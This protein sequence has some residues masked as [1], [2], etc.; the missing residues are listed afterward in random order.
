VTNSAF[1]GAALLGHSGIRARPGRGGDGPPGREPRPGPADGLGRIVAAVPPAAFL[2]AVSMIERR[3]ARRPRLIA[4]EDGAAGKPSAPGRPSPVPD[5]GDEALLAAARRGAAEHQDQRGQPITRDA[6][7]ARL[8]V[9]T[10]GWRAPAR[11]SLRADPVL[12]AKQVIRDAG[13]TRGSSR[14]VS[15]RRTASRDLVPAHLGHRDRRRPAPLH[16]PRPSNPGLV[17]MAQGTVVRPPGRR[18]R[19][20]AGRRLSGS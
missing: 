15:A 10:K 6:L 1:T 16:G 4:G 14:T 7:R 13:D 12:S 9:S 11:D 5:A 18:Y 20:A 8:G 2:V 3:A 19:P 17:P